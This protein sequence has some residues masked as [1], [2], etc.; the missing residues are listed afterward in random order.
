MPYIIS[1][2]ED[3]FRTQQQ[4]L[5]VI[6]YRVPDEDNAED[7]EA[8]ESLFRQAHKQAQKEL[9][10]WF[11]EWLPHTPL[12]IIGA[13]EYSGWMTGGPTYF[14]ADFD[15][16]GLALFK[17]AWDENSAWY[18][19]VWSISDWRK[20]I[21]ETKLLQS[22]VENLQKMRWWDTPQGILLLSAYTSDCGYCEDGFLSLKD[23]WWKLQQL[24]PEL[25]EHQ[26][27]TFPCGKFWPF[28][29]DDK[30]HTDIFVE[31]VYGQSWDSKDYAN[32]HQNLQQLAETIGIPEGI[33]INME[34]EV[35]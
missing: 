2:P 30:S 28:R 20:R 9:N 11:D 8:D 26:A 29:M 1:T 12:R 10:A 18:V 25:S 24:F 22:P 33:T 23:G 27:K 15:P 31:Y 16:D 5:Y 34:I 17:S 3:W 6:Q 35:F 13:S 14:T 19:E 7:Q 4:D 32:N 21:D